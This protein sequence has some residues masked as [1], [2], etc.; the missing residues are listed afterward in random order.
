MFQILLCMVQTCF[1]FDSLYISESIKK[2]AVLF[3]FGKLLFFYNRTVV[4]FWYIEI[5]VVF[6]VC[7]QLAFHINLVFDFY[8][9]LL[10][11]FVIVFIDLLLLQ[12][13]YFILVVLE[14][15]LKMGSISKFNMESLMIKL[16]LQFEKFRRAVLVQYVL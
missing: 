8:Y 4:H 5:L 12:F 3:L 9:L 6:M 14:L 13:Y 16:V 11:L 2:L 15:M 7:F 10:L 1:L